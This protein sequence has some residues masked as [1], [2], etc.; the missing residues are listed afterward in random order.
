MEIMQNKHTRNVISPFINQS[1]SWDDED[2]SILPDLK[3]GIIE[4]LGFL[5]PSK[6]Q[7]VAIPLIIGEVDKNI[8][9]L[10]AQ[11]KNGSGKTGAFSIGTTM[12]VDRKILKP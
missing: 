9:D 4:G 8:C 6:I 2:L 3:K 10:I 5:K 7:A 12:R 11:S 1:K